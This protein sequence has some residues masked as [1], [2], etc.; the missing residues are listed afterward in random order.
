MQRYINNV[1]HG[2]NHIVT[3][4]IPYHFIPFTA[5]LI[6]D[7]ICTV[8]CYKGETFSAWLSYLKFTE[9]F[10]HKIC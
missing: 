1:E 4:A 9:N 5:A 10:I 8:L 3:S 2:T 7:Q 6:I